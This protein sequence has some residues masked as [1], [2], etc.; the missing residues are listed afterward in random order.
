MVGQKEQAHTGLRRYK[1]TPYVQAPSTAHIVWKREGAIG[2]LIGGSQGFLSFTSGGG[3]PS[4]IY[5]GRA[6]QTVTKVSQT[7]TGSQSYWQSYNLRTGEL[8]WERPIYPGETAPSY[9]EYSKSD[10]AVSGGGADVGVSVNLLAI[11][12]TRY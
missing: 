2:G 10:P 5:Q 3:T 8:Y 7:G 11:T 12:N 4:I 9:I 1:F 6:Y